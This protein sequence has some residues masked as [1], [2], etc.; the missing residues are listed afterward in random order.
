MY[1]LQS[2]IEGEREAQKVQLSSP[3]FPC[4][5]KGTPWCYFQ[6]VQIYK[7]DTIEICLW[8]YQ[9]ETKASIH[10]WIPWNT[11]TNLEN[12]RDNNL[13]SRYLY[14]MLWRYI[15]KACFKKNT[16]TL[17]QVS[18]EYFLKTLSDIV[19]SI[20]QSTFIGMEMYLWESRFL[21]MFHKYYLML[22]FY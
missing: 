22:F 7:V 19:N 11:H 18:Y 4:L 2:E 20:E 16:Y 9:M 6:T 1:A 21:S 14:S 10:S 12:F 3:K 17:S 15:F 8:Y 5:P 13:F